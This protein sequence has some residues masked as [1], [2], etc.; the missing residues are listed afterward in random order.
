MSNFVDAY[1]SFDA[2]YSQVF[3]QKIS[4]Q[5]GEAGYSS[6]SD[7]GTDDANTHR[8]IA[9]AHNFV[10]VI[11]PDAVDSARCLHE[12]ELAVEFG[13][14]VIPILQLEV[15]TNFDMM[16]TIIKK[17][18][19]IYATQKFEPDRYPQ[20]WKEEKPF[21]AAF[22]ELIRLVN[23]DRDYVE[24]H[25]EILVRA[26]Q[27]QSNENN[28][29]DL[30]TGD[31]LNAAL[32][33]LTTEFAEP[34]QPPCQPSFL[35]SE[36]ICESKKE[37]DGQITTVLMLNDEADTK[38]MDRFNH[39]LQRRGITT[40][41]M[42]RDNQNTDL[43]I[44]LEAGIRRTDNVLIF[45]SPRLMDS[46]TFQAAFD[47]ARKYNKRIIPVIIES[48]AP[49]SMP[50]ELRAMSYTDF[51]KLAESDYK[52]ELDQIYHRIITEAD[53]YY[54][55]KFFL[56]QALKWKEEEHH[57]NILL[58][59]YNLKL[60]ESWLKIAE[61]RFDHPAL[62]VHQEYIKASLTEAAKLHPEIFLSFSQNETE[63]VR[64]LY[65][66]LQSRGKTAWFEPDNFT[67]EADANA[68][69]IKE[70][71]EQADNFVYI[72]SPHSLA[73]ELPMI[74]V[75]HA[76]KCGK[77]IITLLY[78]NVDT[79]SETWCN[80]GLDKIQ[81]IDFRPE[82]DEFREALGELLRTL[83]TDRDYIRA[84]TKWQYRARAWAGDESGEN[85][86]AIKGRDEL[87]LIG[88]ELE[89]AGNWLQTALTEKKQ[90][91]PTPLL[92]L[93]IR[94]SQYQEH[95]MTSVKE[96][97]NVLLKDFAL[98]NEWNN[99]YAIKLEI[100]K[101]QIQS[102]NKKID[103][104]PQSRK[105]LCLKIRKKVKKNVLIFIPVWLLVIFSISFVFFSLN[106]TFIYTDDTTTRI[107][108]S[109]MITLASFA[110]ILIFYM[111]FLGI[112][113]LIEPEDIDSLYGD[114][115]ENEEFVCVLN[116]KIERINDAEKSY[117]S[118]NNDFE[119]E[120]SADM[121]LFRLKELGEEVDEIKSIIKRDI[122]AEIEAERKR[123]EEEQSSS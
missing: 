123:K 94:R 84:Y 35:H 73:S 67:A 9:R 63:F 88:R 10:Y 27:W 15:T 38:Q 43:K 83:D 100:I 93:F 62:F 16:H 2:R 107:M 7:S 46:Q 95:Q 49:E 34:N 115:E 48:T 51:S 47:W 37:N 72:I 104:Y 32:K 121:V 44:G 60:A 105:D 87:L 22:A 75:A 64:H 53:Y 25:T 61:T 82:L 12:I 21:E 40:W 109:I 92:E 69:E 4:T 28:S 1:I 56:V 29:Q 31:K 14:R 85:P 91:P 41:V 30:L 76:Q 103:N 122:E 114:I 5:L 90:P 42:T 79:T 86:D 117:H 39:Y 108:I 111:I 81:W 118:I 70:R 19:W 20:I 77:R 80:S 96:R 102:A 119:S 97:L 66:E 36:Y 78:E 68:A 58:T 26:L 52:N 65:D 110:P 71:I 74:E 54:K 6:Y 57:P 24:Q 3:A 98:I 55:H 113:S 116:E 17:T 11:T 106:S 45:I 120:K 89:F 99:N 8:R 33:W 13:K 101:A 23:V 59:G 18:N 112:M 50:A